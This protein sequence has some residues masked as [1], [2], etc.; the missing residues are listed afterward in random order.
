MFPLL[1][2]SL[3]RLYLQFGQNGSNL[4]IRILQ[5]RQSR[6]EDTMMS[7]LSLSMLNLKLIRQVLLMD[8]NRTEG[9]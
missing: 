7:I 6:N 9:L 5:R 8:L 3:A 2:L 4:S 1:D